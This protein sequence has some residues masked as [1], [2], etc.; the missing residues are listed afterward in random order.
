[1]RKKCIDVFE[2][3]NTNPELEYSFFLLFSC[4]FQTCS[5]KKLNLFTR[6]TFWH[7]RYCLEQR[8]ESI[9]LF[10]CQMQTGPKYNSPAQWGGGG[11]VTNLPWLNQG[12]HTLHIDHTLVSINDIRIK[13]LNRQHFVINFEGITPEQTFPLNFKMIMS[14]RISA[15]RLNVSAYKCVFVQY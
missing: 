14:W 12:F 6:A 9:N 3:F 2:I 15:L 13:I 10:Y 1:M 11:P 7:G 4:F 8:S 5:R